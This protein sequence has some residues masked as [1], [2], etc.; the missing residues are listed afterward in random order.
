LSDIAH[1]AAGLSGFRAD[2]NVFDGCDGNGSALFSG[3]EM[4]FIVLREQQA[5]NV[6]LGAFEADDVAGDEAFGRGGSLGEG[7]GRQGEGE[8]KDEERFE[9]VNEFDA[10]LVV[11]GTGSKEEEEGNRGSREERMQGCKE[12]WR[13]TERTIEDLKFEISE[14]RSKIPRVSTTCG[15]HS[16]YKSES[17]EGFGVE[18]ITDYGGDVL[19]LG[20]N[21]VVEGL[22]VG[23]GDFAGEQLEGGADF[24]MRGEDFRADDG[25]G[26]VG[27]EIVFVVGED[28]EVAGGKKAIGGI[29]C[30]EIHLIIEKCSIE[31]A[32]I[33]DAGRGGEFQIVGAGEA[34]VAVGAF[35]EFVAEAGAPLRSD[36]GGA[37]NCG[38][39]VEAGV[40][41][42]DDD[43]EGVVEAEGGKDFEMEA[44]RVFIVNFLEDGLGIGLDW[45]F[46]D[47][48]QGSAGVFDVGVNATRED[49][50]L[51]DVGSAEIED[52]VYF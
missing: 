18:E 11:G 29:P 23:R 47:G 35:I 45:I 42:A 15:A 43:G 4:D 17:D 22:H 25:D 12:T 50:L 27:R 31:E 7:G 49:G 30:D 32:E 9:H 21:G 34:G 20:V 38:E 41:S 39:M 28:G 37:G 46:Q 52:A 8:A 2:E 40:G 24:W 33:H 3:V 10:I 51:A 13:G 5:V 36:G 44:L 1:H 14:A 16:K 26:V 6:M 48:G 19:M